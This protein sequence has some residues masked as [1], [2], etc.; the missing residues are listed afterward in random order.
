[1]AIER[2]IDG[3]GYVFETDYGEDVQVA[4]IVV[5]CS[6]GGAAGL[7][8][9]QADG[10]LESAED[11]EG[12]GPNPAALDGV[13]PEPPEELIEDARRMAERKLGK[14]ATQASDEES[15]S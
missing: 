2:D 9:V 4:R 7:F 15:H 11:L 5:R 6:A 14:L 10:S 3:V 8:L 1:M 12:F 13:W